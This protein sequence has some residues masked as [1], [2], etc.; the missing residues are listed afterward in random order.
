MTTN[1]YE[2]ILQRRRMTAILKARIQSHAFLQGFLHQQKRVDSNE[3]GEPESKGAKGKTPTNIASSKEEKI[4]KGQWTEPDKYG[5]SYKYGDTP[6]DTQQRGP[7]YMLVE[8]YVRPRPKP[9][10]F[11]PFSWPS[12]TEMDHA[13]EVKENYNTG[14]Y[15]KLTGAELRQQRF[16]DQ[17]DKEGRVFELVGTA[18]VT[19]PVAIGSGVVSG[20]GSLG[21]QGLRAA[22]P[23]AGRG[24]SLG[25]QFF[26][27]RFTDPSAYAAAAADY[28]IQRS[29]G[30]TNSA[31]NLTSIGLSWLIPGGGT[32]KAQLLAAGA[33]AFGASAFEYSGEKGASNTIFTG[34]VFS[35][36]AL[37]SST[38][39]IGN[40]LG[41]RMGGGL[42]SSLSQAVMRPVSKFGAEA[43]GNFTGGYLFIGIG[44]LPVK[45][46]NLSQK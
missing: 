25:W 9:T 29:M 17:M 12:K 13:R 4:V 14:R 41:S 36:I 32:W 3:P 40:F 15:S 2:M 19:V 31:V 45:A 26:K 11:S 1:E 42:G 39:T 33:Q 6:E 8:V 18:I 28:S 43:F 44:A 34:K 37:E 27:S 16:F 10:G 5:F 23:Y 20:I 22:A 35:Q 21:W 24:L 30:S 7:H 46:F 38:G